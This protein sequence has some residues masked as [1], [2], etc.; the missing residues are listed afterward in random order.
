MTRCTIH[1]RVSG[2][3]CLLYGTIIRVCELRCV[4]FKFVTFLQSD[5]GFGRRHL[6]NGGVGKSN[7][8]HSLVSRSVSQY[9]SSLG[10]QLHLL[11]VFTLLSC[12]PHAAATRGQW[13]CA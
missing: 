9:S 5:Y 7:S 8:E 6:V 12:R 13:R 3:L 1:L 2:G 4:D 11:Y 10:G